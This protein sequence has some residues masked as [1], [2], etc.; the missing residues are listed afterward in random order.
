[1]KRCSTLLRPTPEFRAL[2]VASSLAGVLACVSQGDYDRDIRRMEAR[3]RATQEELQNQERSSQALAQENIRLIEEL[4]EMRLGRDGLA[5]NVEE[6]SRARESLSARLLERNSRLEELSQASDTYR[7]LVADLQSEVT[8]GQIEIEQLRDGIRLNLPQSI[9]FPSGAVKLDPRG[10]EVLRKVSERLRTNTH[11]IE[12]R[13][14]SDDKQLV[15]GLAAR[16]GTNWE[17]AGARA[18]SVVRLFHA[19]G[20]DG[21]RMTAVSY[22][23][24]APV[25]SNSTPEGRARNRRIEIRLIPQVRDAEAS[26]P[27]GDTGGAPQDS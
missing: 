14:H 9:L 10:A 16:F 11:R 27:V 17:L 21:S 8:S 24:F 1:M 3:Q 13:G 5:R 20:V 6:L 19:E 25:A 26:A 15:R 12:V 22:G 23:R 2:L 4:E 18:S 7:G